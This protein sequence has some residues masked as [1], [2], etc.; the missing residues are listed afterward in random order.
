MAAEPWIR[1]HQC[2]AC[3]TNNPNATA[4]PPERCAGCGEA[5]QTFRVVT[6]SVSF[7]GYSDGFSDDRIHR[8]KHRKRAHA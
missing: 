2:V 5:L 4:T 1:M 8:R 6:P 3:G 7:W